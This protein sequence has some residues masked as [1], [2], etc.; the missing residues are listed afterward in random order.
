[1]IGLSLAL[2]AGSRGGLLALGAFAASA[3]P[4]TARDQDRIQCIAESTAEARFDPT[5][6]R[7]VNQDVESA[8]IY[9]LVWTGGPGAGYSFRWT[10]NGA[11]ADEACGYFR[12]NGRDS[13]DRYVCG[14]GLEIDMTQLRYSRIDREAFLDDNSQ[15][16]IV[17]LGRCELLI[18]VEDWE[19]F[20]F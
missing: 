11:L 17:E 18:P 14:R 10:E 13:S 3:V 16:V 1:M 12:E 7:W 5:L 19:Y 6:N 15:P 20:Y 8:R 9:T 4:A 2:M